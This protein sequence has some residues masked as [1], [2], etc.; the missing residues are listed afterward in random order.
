[1]NSD[2]HDELDGLRDLGATLDE[3]IE[4]IAAFLAEAAHARVPSVAMID[5][6]HEVV[7]NLVQWR[8]TLEDIVARDDDAEGMH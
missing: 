8:A 5:R 4:T 6:A 3:A 1:M 7:G 2:E